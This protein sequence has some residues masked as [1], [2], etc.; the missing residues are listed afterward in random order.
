MPLAPHS[1]ERVARS[2]GRGVRVKIEMAQIKQIK[3]APHP[4]PSPRCAGETGTVGIVGFADDYFFFGAIIMTICRPS[5][6]GRDSTTM[7]SPRSAS[8]RDAISRPSS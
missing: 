8:I 7:S 5:R 2:A 1:G 4:L 3:G 6:R